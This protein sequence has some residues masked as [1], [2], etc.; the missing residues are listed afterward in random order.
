MNI[1][2]TTKNDNNDKEFNTLFVA[3]GKKQCDQ[4]N[5]INENKILK[6]LEMVKQKKLNIFD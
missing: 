4:F 5:A 3:S 1:D 2:M 6:L